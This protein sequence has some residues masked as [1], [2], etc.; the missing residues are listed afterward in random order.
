M[1]LF[2]IDIDNDSMWIAVLR[3]ILVWTLAL[4]IG[5]FLGDYF[6]NKNVGCPQL[7][8]SLQKEVKYNFLAGGCFIKLSNENWIS[9]DNYT[10]VNIEN[11]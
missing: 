7:G 1:N 4:F 2:K 9:S 5:I 3:P 6:Y 11:R 10:G 8:N